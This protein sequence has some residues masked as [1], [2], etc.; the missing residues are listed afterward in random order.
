MVRWWGV[1]FVLVFFVSENYWREPDSLK[2]A[3]GAN[4]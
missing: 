4:S 1:C 3:G 2:M